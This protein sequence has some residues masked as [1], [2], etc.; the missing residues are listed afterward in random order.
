VTIPD[1]AETKPS[2]PANGL[3][4]RFSHLYH[5]LG[6]FGVVGGVAFLVDLTIYNLLLF[7]WGP[8]PSSVV[9][10]V[11]AATLAFIGNRYW[12]WRDRERSSLA[13][14]YSLYFFFN[15]VGLLITLAVVW[16]SH[17][18]LGSRWPDIFQTRIADNVAKMIIGTGLA[19]LFR[20]WAYRRFVFGSPAAQDTPAAH[21]ASAKING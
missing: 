17:D 12:T 11:I 9:S 2:S 21:A 20:F 18:V 5:E 3:L 6:K 1:V 13:R 14:E 4:G 16:L 8:V 19:S 10:T 7:V 15:F